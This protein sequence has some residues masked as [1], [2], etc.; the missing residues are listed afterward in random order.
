MAG[1]KLAGFFL[2]IGFVGACHP[3]PTHELVLADVAMKAAQKAK[4]DSLVPDSFR[5]AENFF[6]RAKKDYS[7]GYFDAAARH[8]NDARLLAE[9]AEFQAF[10]KQ[11]QIRG[12]ADEPSDS[13]G[14]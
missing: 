5:K 10:K 9:Q 8:A 3:R 14:N 1:L 11:S 12:R 7:E 4:A 13:G 6:L 2:L